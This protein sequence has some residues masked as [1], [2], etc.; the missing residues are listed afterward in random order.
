MARPKK[1]DHEVTPQALKMRER[2][3][4]QDKERARQ[5]SSKGWR[6]LKLEVLQHYS[7]LEIP[8]C[9]CCIETTIEFLHLDHG[10]GDG[11][12]H[13]R[14]LKKMGTNV[15]L[16]LK[17][18]GYPDDLGFQ[19]LCS[20]CDFGKKDKTYCPHEL[21][22]GMDMNG[23]P[24]SSEYYSKRIEDLSPRKTTR[25]YRL[26]TG[27]TRSEYQKRWKTENAD[28]FKLVQKRSMDAIRFEC[29]QHYSGLEVPEC[30]CC[31][32]TMFEFLQLDH[33]DGDGAAHK[34]FMIQING[35]N[36]DGNAL[37]YHLKNNNFPNEPRLQVLCVKCNFGKRIGKYCPHELHNH[38]DIDGQ[39]I[40]DKFY[41]PQFN[42]M[43][44]KKGPERDVW[45][46]SPE[47]LAFIQKQSETHLGKL[48]GEDHPRWAGD[49]LSVLCAECGAQLE[50]KPWEKEERYFCNPKCRG[51]WASKNLVGE[52]VYNHTPDIEFVCGYSG[53]GK[54]IL[55]KQHELRPGQSV[56]YCDKTCTDRAKVGQTAWNKGVT[57]EISCTTCGNILTKK[58]SEVDRSE[59]KRFFCNQKC[60]GIWKSQNGG[61]K[62]TEEAKQKIRE[63]KL[64]N[65]TMLGRTHSE[66]TKKKLKQK[67]IEREAKKRQA[68]LNINTDAAMDSR[69]SSDVLS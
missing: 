62:H 12:E 56:V 44:H 40:P 6:K 35:K 45:S 55:R 51:I 48:V 24:I 7:G 59:T 39:P 66:E 1:P 49:R 43:P 3:K 69:H 31:K 19:V 64:G 46:T 50:R 13:R 25:P 9:R 57:V 26:S 42:W 29:L 23:K 2:R 53:C 16:W 32:E 61:H 67:A 58:Q 54:P 63:A 60:A 28:R 11:A 65:T 47:G 27:E 17:K 21:K 33:I 5:I 8:E 4:N 14:Q 30:R 52:R 34:K 20:N 68:S 10:F 36:I 38:R 18:N 41:S 22:R 15:Y 37:Y